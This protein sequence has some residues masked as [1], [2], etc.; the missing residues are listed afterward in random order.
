MGILSKIMDAVWGTDDL[1]PTPTRDPVEEAY[2]GTDQAG[3]G[4]VPQLRAT[5]SSVTATPA[6]V[7]ETAPANTNPM[8]QRNDV[9]VAKQL[10][11]ATEASGQGLNWRTSI[12]DLMKAVGMDASLEERRELAHE[13]KY[14]GDMNDAESMNMFLHKELL[15]R[16][17]E[18]GG[19]VPPELL[20]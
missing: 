2:L 3:T 19:R 15:K 13:L 8:P 6:A 12:I 1:T 20:G 14:P 5:E 10:D 11:Q 4:F 9:D 16:L 7:P 17:S 18:N